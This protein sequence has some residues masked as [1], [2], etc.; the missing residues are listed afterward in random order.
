[1]K[2]ERL[3][4]TYTVE[5]F[6]SETGEIVPWVFVG[7]VR[8]GCHDE[9]G[10][11]G[12]T[13]AGL[14]SEVVEASE[15]ARKAF[16]DIVERYGG[17]HPKDNLMVASNLREAV[18]PTAKKLTR[19]V[20]PEELGAE[21]LAAE[22]PLVIEFRVDPVLNQVPWD[23]LF[24]GQDF[25][26]F[27]HATGRSVMS[28]PACPVTPNRSRQG[29]LRGAFIVD[30]CPVG[31]DRLED[32]LVREAMQLLGRW[33]QGVGCDRIRFASEAMRVRD[34]IPAS[35]LS[36]LLQH[37]DLVMVL[38]HNNDRGRATAEAPEEEGLLIMDEQGRRPALYSPAEMLTALQA[39]NVP[40]ELLFWLACESALSTGWA[41]D[42]PNNRRIYGFVDAA[43]RAGVRHFIGSSVVVPQ[44]VA[45]DLVEPFL[46]EVAAGCSVGEALRRARVAARR[47]SPDPADGGSFVGLAFSLFGPPSLG[48]LSG[49]GCRIGGLVAHP[50]RHVEKR[51]RCGALY[52][53][54]DM[55][56]ANQR[57][58]AHA[59][60]PPRPPLLREPCGNPYGKHTDAVAW[61]TALDEGWAGAIQKKESGDLRFLRLCNLCWD[62]ALFRRELVRL[63]DLMN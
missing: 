46:L 41:K 6:P 36:A 35:R 47:G 61:V 54:G 22:A 3:E 17:P 12:K 59:L 28:Q 34:P 45:M 50:C 63:A 39:P 62:E 19:L 48:L 18:I 25:L 57:C 11:L 60:I 43:V 32:Q 24:L 49:G 31:A 4:L 40:P 58:A 33:G 30:P 9:K 37:S 51:V 10:G 15:R 23:L 56:A 26:S 29:V 16:A 8:L 13:K 21:I 53:P 1:M 20:I 7:V 42:W 27:T 2:L 44:A 14:M 5:H 55:G 52:E 38:G